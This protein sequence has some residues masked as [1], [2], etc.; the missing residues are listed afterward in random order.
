MLTV[1]C[2]LIEQFGKAKCLMKVSALGAVALLWS[3]IPEPKLPAG[4]V[5]QR[6]ASPAATASAL[7]QALVGAQAGD[8][9]VAAAGRYQAALTVPA[10]VSL[11]GA[12]GAV[13]ALAGEV[14]GGPVLT[15]S[16]KANAA[17]L[18]VVDAPNLGVLLSP[19][20]QLL[21]VSVSNASGI[22]VVAWCEEDCLVA[23]LATLTNVTVTE[24]AV[25]LW[26][27][28]ARL[29]VVGGAVSAN[30]S[31]SL[32]SGYG[33]VASHGAVL[34][35][36]RTIIENNEDVGLLVD[37]TQETA[38]ALNDARIRDNRGRGIW[39]QG[40]QG[41]ALAP[42]LELIS[43]A[44]EGNALAGLGA[45]SS[46]GVSVRGGRIAGTLLAKTIS[47]QPGVLIDV[48]DGVGLF[49]HSGEAALENVVIEGNERAQVLVDQAGVGVSV[50][51]GTIMGGQQ[52]VVVQR[53]S[54]MVQAPN[55]VTPMA[56]QELDVSAPTLNVPQR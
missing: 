10:G 35:M 26:A 9:V 44:V 23:E 13:V 33:V 51:G 21:D 53:S 15:L 55:I 6:V 20:A 18:R 46:K 5:C 4:I 16:A 27:R 11:V 30:R 1:I 31:T 43:C 54:A 38:A 47:A 12:E 14:S 41:T 19:G 3:C 50:L 34:T 22:G 40:L 24:N 29:K 49:D 56:G 25:G 42:K 32:A 36:E 2:V 39:A 45:R 17:G 8:C 7:K 28:G 52:G 48:G 37:G